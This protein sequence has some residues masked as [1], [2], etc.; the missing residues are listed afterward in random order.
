MGQKLHAYMEGFV[1][2]AEYKIAVG[3]WPFSNQTYNYSAIYTNQ[4]LEVYFDNLCIHTVFEAK[5]FNLP[6]TI[7]GFYPL[8]SHSSKSKF[9]I[10]H[11]SCNTKNLFLVRN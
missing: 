11:S 6:Q 10:T 5:Q 3:P 7:K 1:E 2:P 4:S 9:L 8:A